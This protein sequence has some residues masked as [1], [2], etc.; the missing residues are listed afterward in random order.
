MSK[1]TP[2]KADLTALERMP[3]G[4]FDAMDLPGVIRCP[5]FRCDRLEKRGLLESK[6]VGSWPN[7]TKLFK[8]VAQSSAVVVPLKRKRK[9]VI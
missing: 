7:A 9:G 2:S 1:E 3:E 8:I 5:R 6:Y 4:W